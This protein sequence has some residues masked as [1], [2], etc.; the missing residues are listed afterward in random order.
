LAQGAAQKAFCSTRT[1]RRLT[2]TRRHDDPAAQA[3]AARLA[4]AFIVVAA[5][6]LPPDDRIAWAQHAPP[7]APAHGDALAARPARAQ[8]D[9]AAAPLRAIQEERL[10]PPDAPPLPSILIARRRGRG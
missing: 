8:R 5:D 10:T 2:K 9:A 4:G 7:E 1:L 3:R 6:S